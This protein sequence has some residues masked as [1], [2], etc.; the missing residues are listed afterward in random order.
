MRKTPVSVLHVITRF[1]RGGADENT[2][3]S[4]NLQA[5]QGLEVHLA[6]G[7]ETNPEILARVDPRVKLHVIPHLVRPISPYSDV[8]AT[9][10]LFKLIRE[11][12][13]D[14]VHTHTS[15]AGIIGRVAAV[16]AGTQVV[17]HGIHILPFLNV[18]KVQKYLYLLLERALAPFTSAF[19][20]VS[21]GMASAALAHGLGSQERH[22]VVHSGMDV[23]K[24]RE[25][26]PLCAEELARALP[27]IDLK[28]T[29]RIVA[30][31]AAL[32]P[33]K[34]VYEFLEVFSRV[35]AKAPDTVLLVLGEGPER[36]RLEQRIAMLGLT[37]K[38]ALLGFRTDVERWIATA[39]V[40]ALS[41][42]REGLPR[43]IVQYAIQAKP[44]IA[45]ALPGVEAI[46][47]EGVTG[48]LVDPDRVDLMED[49]LVRLISDSALTAQMSA[50]L[51]QHDFSPWDSQRMADELYKLYL[52]E[53]ERH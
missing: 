28:R 48:F 2:L 16:A 17:V 12:R 44:I 34:R 36:Q 5:E 52:K 6:V 26:R 9:F 38:V 37:T 46:V 53:L 27:W 43:A 24:H 20:S 19:V 39:H 45:T 25:A 41:S 30:M 23:R 1:I 18:G 33:R 29:T 49:P 31:V 15:K 21:E 14:I 42:E 8:A 50:A 11:Q 47:K 22:L 3:L 13:P 35:V 51:Q 32:E 10:A 4:C 7:K 40:C